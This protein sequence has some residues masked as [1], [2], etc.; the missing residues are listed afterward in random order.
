MA[1]LAIIVNVG[2]EKGEVTMIAHDDGT[3][4]PVTTMEREIGSF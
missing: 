2:R 4:N 3:G 1:R